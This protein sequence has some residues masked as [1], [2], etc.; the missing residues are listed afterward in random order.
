V[1]HT[2]SASIQ[3]EADVVLFDNGTNSC[4]EAHLSLE[5]QGRVIA[6]N[7]VPGVQ[8]TMTID[9]QVEC[10]QA[11]LQSTRFQ[12]LLRE[13]Y[14]IDDVSL[15]MVDIWSTGYYG[16]EEERTRRLAYDQIQRTT[17]MLIPLKD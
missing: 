2:A 14:S 7:H 1:D 9:E 16:Q 5:G 10:E 15:V 11:V 8:P 12:E 4:Y 6:L 13:H 3:R 17:A